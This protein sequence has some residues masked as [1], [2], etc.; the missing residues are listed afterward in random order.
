MTDDN[1]L[2]GLLLERKLSRLIRIKEDRLAQCSF[3][4]D[5]ATQEK[6]K[7]EYTARAVLELIKIACFPWE[8]LV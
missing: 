1:R 5:P 8:H 6:W 7:L 3:Y 2:T 4:L